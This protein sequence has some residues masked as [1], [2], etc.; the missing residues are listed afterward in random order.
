MKKTLIAMM[1]AVLYSPCFAVLTVDTCE[2]GTLTN[3]KG[4][5]WFTYTDGISSVTLTANSAPGYNASAYCRKVDSIILNPDVYT[6]FT[7]LMTTLNPSYISEDLSAYYGVRFFAKGKADVVVSIPLDG[8]HNAAC[9]Y[10]DYRKALAVDSEEWQLFEIPFNRL[11]QGGWGC[12]AAWD[13]ATVQGVQFAFGGNIG[14]TAVLYLDNIEFYKEDEAINTPNAVFL[15]LKPK[16]NQIGYLPSQKKLFS[17]VTQTASTGADFQVKRVLDDSSVLSGNISGGVISDPA[18]GEGVVSGDFSGLNTP[19]EYYVEVNNQ[20]SYNFL[21]ADDAYD[22]LFKDALRGFY[23]IRCGTDMNDPV[24]GL[25]HVACHMADGGYND[26]SGTGDLTGGWHNA[27]DFGK[28]THEHA[29]SVAYMLWLY[30]LK[31]QAM[32]GLDIN[33]PE[34]GGVSDILQQIGRAHV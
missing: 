11:S 32:Q 17:V 18:A 19:G 25:V 3:T 24:T 20:R 23:S 7:G 26:K 14:T 27:G 29:F 28:W 16:I 1:F 30:E 12:T 21:I 33:T 31:T 2:T 34:S 8:T 15:S 5:H 10:D 9:N 4:G 6:S 22:T 13:A